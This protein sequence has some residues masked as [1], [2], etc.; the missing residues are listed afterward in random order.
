MNKNVFF[1]KYSD[2]GDGWA[3]K[4][5]FYGDSDEEAYTKLKNFLITEGFKDIPLPPTARRL[6]LDYLKPNKDG[7]YVGYI[8]H[9]IKIYQDAYQING[10]L[11]II[12]DDNHPNH[13][14]LWEGNMHKE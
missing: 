12:C 5:G 14:E 10:L 3:Y 11:L 2:A 9:P 13:L 1:K 4:F 7:D 6:W 8:W